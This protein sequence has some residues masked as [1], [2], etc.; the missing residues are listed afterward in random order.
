MLV[1]KAWI[2][3]FGESLVEMLVLEACLV[4]LTKSVQQECPDKR[5]KQEF[6]G[7]ERLRR[8]SFITVGSRWSWVASG[9]AVLL[10]NATADC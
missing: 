4:V 5:V 6:M 8:V 10:G 1:L 2:V 3:T 7:C 9:C